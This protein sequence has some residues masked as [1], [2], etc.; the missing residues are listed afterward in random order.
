MAVND[1]V[2]M[3]SALWAVIWIV[4]ASGAYLVQGSAPQ[5]GSP[6]EGPNPQAIA[7]LKATKCTEANAAWWG[8]DPEDSTAAIQAAI[9]SGAKRVI[10]PRMSTPWIVDKIE[11][12]SD[13]EIFFEPGT[14]V[15]AK[16]GAFRGKT[17]SLF[18]ARNKRNIR[19]IGPGA[20]LRMRRSDYAA[21]PYE[22]AEWR[23]VLALYGCTNVLVEGLTLAE[24][25]GD[26]IYLGAGRNGEPNCDIVIRD[27][28]CENN[29]R[30]GI[31]VITAKNL[32]I[33]R[34]TLRGTG[35]TPPAAGIDF[36]PNHPTEVLVNCLMRNCVIENNEGL[37][38][39][40]YLANLN[41]SSEPVS[42]RI[43]DCITR[44]S[45]ARS[46]HL[47]TGNGPGKAVPGVVEVVRCR[48]E[49]PG[50]AG[51]L[52]RSKPVGGLRLIFS[53]CVIVDPEE[54]PAIAAPIT[55]L[56][57][58]GDLEP[59]GGVD[60][61]NMLIVEK[62]ARRPI[63]FGDPAMVCLQNISGTI[64]VRRPEGETVF[65]VDEALLADWYPCPP[66]A[67]LPVRQVDERW[68]KEV[69]ASRK[70]QEQVVPPHRLRFQ[71]NYAFWVGAGE[72]VR[73]Q[74]LAEG[75]GP[76]R[77]G[78][79]RGEITTWEGKRI[80]QVELP[81]GKST[82]VAFKCPREGAYL[83]TVSAGLNTVR[84][85]RASHPVAILAQRDSVRFFQTAGS[86]WICLP[87]G[88]S[89]G[90][91]VAGE[92][93]AERVSVEIRDQTG[94]SLWQ[95]ENVALPE[96][97]TVPGQNELQWLELRLRRPSEGILEDVTVRVRGVPALLFFAPPQ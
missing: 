57:N 1:R 47:M 11:L 82:A 37:G 52:V 97:V 34:V 88:E 20:I 43:E 46:F 15:L 45:N 4:A 93:E 26:G 14:E 55:F 62:V 80:D 28:T 74:L 94:N 60:F 19:L 68:L 9:R 23:H 5:N 83:V 17:D 58:A 71:A 67:R 49:E 64:T 50:R 27:V 2:G 61:V 10:V 22:K 12:E 32:L 76:S 48:F 77:S 18:T 29:Y 91:A 6:D 38:L 70:W 13:Q 42:I 39:H 79:V 41:A 69:L 21:S 53:D 59:V 16:K 44:G 33:E 84:L 87:P 7:E 95:R 89:M 75:V 51:I 25:G 65:T 78:S 90:L 72:E 81:L 8:F 54:K 66:I 35:G 73:L 3:L 30:Q 56:S 31:S 24:S 36:E 40:L 92:S 63:A 85:L 86:F 96:S